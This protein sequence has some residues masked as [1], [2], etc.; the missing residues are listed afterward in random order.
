VTRAL[1]TID[2]RA[3]I[4]V[5]LNELTIS[6]NPVRR[7][8]Q[9]PCTAPFSQTAVTT[10]D[11]PQINRANVG[12]DLT[13][14]GISQDAASVVVSIDD[15]DP[16]TPPVSAAPFTPASPTGPQTWTV[17]IPAAQVAGLSDGTI[18]ASMAPTGRTMTMV[19][20]TVAPGL[21]GATPAPGTYGTAQSVTLSAEAGATIHY[22]NNGTS[23]TAGSPT[24]NGP[25]PVTSTQTLKAI[26]VDAAGNPGPMGTFAYTITPPPPPPP[27]APPAAPVTTPAGG[28]TTIVNQTILGP[29]GVA[30]AP[31][32]EAIT[33]A[34]SKPTLALKQLGIS[35]SIKQL[36]AQKSGVRLILR[37]STGTEVLKVN[38]YR[39]NATG[40]KLLSS[41]F[42]VAPTGTGVSHVA[43]SQP[44]LRRLLTKGNYVVQVTPGYARNELGKTSSASFK[45]V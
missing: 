45:V 37:V 18:T 10:T 44:A 34:S 19:K 11:H 24:A 27:P 36:K 33:T 21:P 35:P 3:V 29:A 20:D 12:T 9:P 32:V 38:V 4:L 23:P 42:K 1:N 2:S 6:Q 26:A 30:A 31:P 17:T 8:P 14:S 43:Q 13:L 7:G 28:G 16:N 40:L 41:G 22:T 25:L 39:K 15:E 5:T